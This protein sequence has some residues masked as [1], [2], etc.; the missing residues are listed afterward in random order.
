MDGTAVAEEDGSG[1]TLQRL[2]RR[3]IRDWTRQLVDVS[4]RNTLLSFR[5]LKAGTLDLARASEEASQALLFGEKVRI[6]DAFGDET[7]DAIRR[8]RAIKARADE[9]DEERGLRTLSVA[10]G[11]ATWTNSVSTYTPQAPVLLC[12]ADLVPRGVAADDFDLQLGDADWE[13]NP[14]LLHVL[15]SNFDVRIGDDTLL[16]LLGEDNELPDGQAVFDRLTKECADVDGFACRTRLV[17]ANF[18]YAKLPM[19]K[20]LEVAE[21]LL[22]A[23]GGST[24]RPGV[25]ADVALKQDGQGRIEHALVAVVGDDKRHRAGFVTNPADDGTEDVGQFWAD[26]Q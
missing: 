1:T 9:N 24:D 15:A 25:G 3:A 20:D 5:P 11:M 18:S 13:I 8:C 2:V 4:G 10:W 22:R 26:D 17:L 14:V 19:V 16:D 6:S 21:E 23:N 12:H 7:A